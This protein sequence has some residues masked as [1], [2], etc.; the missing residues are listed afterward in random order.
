MY[1]LFRIFDAPRQ[2]RRFINDSEQFFNE[3]VIH[4][5]VKIYNPQARLAYM[6]KE[7]RTVL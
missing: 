2:P 4:F 7:W 1:R 5:L 3:F 6:I